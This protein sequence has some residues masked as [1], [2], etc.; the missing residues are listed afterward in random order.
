MSTI[1]LYDIANDA[2]FGSIS[3]NVAKIRYVPAHRPDA[4]R[5]VS[6][7][8]VGVDLSELPELYKKLGVK[9]A[10]DG[11]G[12]QYTLPM[13]HDQKTGAAAANSLDIALYLDATYPATPRLIPAGTGALHAVLTAMWS[14]KVGGPISAFTYPASFPLFKPA[15]RKFFEDT[16]R[17][18]AGMVFSEEAKRAKWAEVKAGLDAMDAFIGA[19]NAY[20]TG[21]SL[22][23]ADLVLAGSLRW[24]KVALSKEQWA[25]IAGW[26]AG[27]WGKLMAEME[28]YD[29]LNA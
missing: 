27:R 1:V 13:I 29:G 17:S 7:Q 12:V 25:E 6:F 15:T 11:G 20:F 21:D 28:K 3:P 19:G 26:N 18:P 5:G 2:P 16:G 23:Y 4:E 14:A 24:A 22:S 8:T 10:S 9:P